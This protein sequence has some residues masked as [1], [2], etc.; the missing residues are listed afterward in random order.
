MKQSDQSA[1][2][3]VST[4]I[5]IAVV[6]CAVIITSHIP[7]VMTAVVLALGLLRAQSQPPS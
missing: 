7:A 3:R 1:K 4:G 5:F 6:I 2:S